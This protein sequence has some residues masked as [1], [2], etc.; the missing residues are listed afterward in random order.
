[1]IN[2]VDLKVI[3][4]VIKFVNNVNIFV[5]LMD[6]GSE[7]GK[8]LIIVVLDNV[9]VGKMVV[10]YVVKKL[11]KKVKVFELFGVLGVFVI[12]DCGKGFYLVVKFKFDIFLS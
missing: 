1:M 8:V 4:I 2:F 6:C 10:D 12:V 11:G 9:V 3:V 7:G 5:I